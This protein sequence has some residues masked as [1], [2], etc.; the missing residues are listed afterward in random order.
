MINPAAE[1]NKFYK[2]QIKYDTVKYRLE[3]FLKLVLQEYAKIK[4][5]L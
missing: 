5:K 4:T 3:N 1:I 2:G